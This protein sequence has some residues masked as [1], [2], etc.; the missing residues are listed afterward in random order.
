MAR[1]EI[2]GNMR[3]NPRWLADFG[4]R[5]AQAVYP[6][7]L[8]QSGFLNQLGVSVLLTAPNNVG[9]TSIAVTALALPLPSITLLSAV[10]TLLIPSGSIIVFD[11]TVGKIAITTA[12]AHQG[13]TSISVQPLPVALAGTETSKWNAYNVDYVPS[14]ILVGRVYAAQGQYVIGDPTIHDDLALLLYEVPTLQLRNDCELLRPNS[15]TTIKENFLYFY[16]LM[17]AD[18]GIADPTTAM[19]LTAAGTDGSL[20]VGVYYVQYAY[21][22]AYGETK[23]S[24]KQTV[25]LASTNHIAIA[26]LGAFPTNATYIKFYVSPAVGDP[27]TQWA[28]SLSTHGATTILTGGTGRGPRNFQEPNNT[29]SGF[30]R[31][32]AWIRQHYNCI[33]G[34][35]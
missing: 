20:G 17:T 27:D 3:S 35:L 1:M 14:A 28:K 21:G 31:Q 10:S 18:P 15:G 19:V 5:R 30:G 4:S 9:D 11:P 32:L 24:P 29:Q 6:A 26:D 22:N 8:S 33:Q 2:Q 12:D 16:S 25:T 34:A 13:D 23:P 7:K